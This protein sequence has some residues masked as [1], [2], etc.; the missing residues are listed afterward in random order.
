MNNKPD[1][2]PEECEFCHYETN[3][4]EFF[5]APGGKDGWLCDVCASTYAGN[6]YHFPDHYENR[7]IMSQVS[8]STN[9]I[10]DAIKKGRR[11]E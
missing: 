5:N 2:K 4:L 9:M 11:D 1:D 10:L 8:Y 7:H 6:A 3:K